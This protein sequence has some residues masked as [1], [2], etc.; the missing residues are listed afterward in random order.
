MNLGRNSIEKMLAFEE[1]H[2]VAS[3]TRVF[4]VI[5]LT[6]LPGLLIILLVAAIPLKIPVLGV[7]GNAAFFVQSFLIHVAMIF[8]LLLFIRCSLGLP[9]QYIHMVK[10]RLSQLLQRH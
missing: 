3:Y 7:K 10:V 1:Y 4:A 5:F 6:P 9:L 2:R 8:S